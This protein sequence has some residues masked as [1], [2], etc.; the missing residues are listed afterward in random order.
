MV[1]SWWIRAGSDAYIKK[2]VRNKDEVP[3]IP[4]KRDEVI[5]PNLTRVSFPDGR[6][7]TV[8]AGD[9]SRRPTD[10]TLNIPSPASEDVEIANRGSQD[11]D[12]PVIDDDQPAATVPE[13]TATAPR[14]SNRDDDQPAATVPEGTTTAPRRSNRV[15]N[16]PKHLEDYEIN[17]E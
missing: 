16:K 14:R 17:I 10:D 4:V 2:H 8:S 12:V 3:V 5:T 6:I 15:R 11:N 9:L 7:D 13:E 1:S